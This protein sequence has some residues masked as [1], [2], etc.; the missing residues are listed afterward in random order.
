MKG[1]PLL[2]GVIALIGLVMIMFYAGMFMHGD[3]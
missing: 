3:S 2:F 1:R